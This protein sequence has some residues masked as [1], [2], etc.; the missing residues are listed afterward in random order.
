MMIIIFFLKNPVYIQ[1]A[2]DSERK[3]GEQGAAREPPPA[4]NSPAGGGE[5]DAIGPD[6]GA[7]RGQGHHQEVAET[8][9]EAAEGA[10]PVSTNEY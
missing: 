4:E 9:G 8:G 3:T 1:P 6:C 5:A 2:K 10:E 7:G